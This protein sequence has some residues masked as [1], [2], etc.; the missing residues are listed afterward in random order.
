MSR[1]DSWKACSPRPRPV[2]HVVHS[3]SGALHWESGCRHLSH[4]LS[5]PKPPWRAFAQPLWWTAGS[6]P[7]LPPTPP[8]SAAQL[9]SG[10]T[11]DKGDSC[12]CFKNSPDSCGFKA[13]DHEDGTC[14]AAGAPG[15]RAP[16]GSGQVLSK[17]GNG[18]SLLV[19]ERAGKRFSD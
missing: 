2:A 17:S 5:P 6:L 12:S 9:L 18:D 19:G 10:G 15:H 7:P 8:C 13:S 3:W 16:E 4:G 14:L 11:R 1:F